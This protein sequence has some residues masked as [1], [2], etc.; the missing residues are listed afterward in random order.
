MAGRRKQRR[1][2]KPSDE[3][4]PG[5]EGSHLKRIAKLLALLAVKGEQQKDQILTL[6]ALGYPA[7]EIAELLRTTAVTVS[8][9]LSRQK[10]QQ[11]KG[12]KAKPPR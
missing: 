9:T 1:P 11:A 2:R 10:S 7:G 3:P 8:V 5:L 4:V 12:R 6:D